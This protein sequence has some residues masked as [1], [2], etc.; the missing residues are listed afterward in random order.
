MDKLPLDCRDVGGLLAAWVDGEL[1]PSEKTDVDGHLLGCAGCAQAAREQLGLKRAVR[2]LGGGS[3]AMPG[4][5]RTRVY[6]G[7]SKASRE[8]RGERFVGW[9]AALD[10]RS[11]ALAAGF[12]GVMTWFL[13]GGLS[14]PLLGGPSGDRSLEDGVAV[15][16][17]TLPLDFTTTDAGA[18]QSW[19]QGKLDYGVHLPRFPARS[20]AQTPRLQ[21]VRL[22][23][24]S[25]RP[26]AVV[27]YTVPDAQSRRVSLLVVDD[28]SV[29]P[30]G[31][32]RHIGDRDVWLS[33]NRGFNVATWKSEQIVYSLISDLDERDVLELVRTAELR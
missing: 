8:R 7:L 24:A 26:A 4:D 14:R 5:L 19:L 25:A 30:S 16:A 15:H 32:A 2:E 29:V 6:A 11:V 9:L 18:V 21:G 27:S 33:K 17:R 23:N 22:S 20:G 12:A 1:L 28:P 10:P 3:P 31:E 13:L